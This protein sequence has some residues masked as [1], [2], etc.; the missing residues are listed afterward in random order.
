MSS[1][2]MIPSAAPVVGDDGAMNNL[3]SLSVLI[4]SN[5]EAAMMLA[6]MIETATASQLEKPAKAAAKPAAAKP[7][8]AVKTVPVSADGAPD[9]SEYRVDEIDHATCVA[10][11]IKGGDDKRWKPAIYREKQCGKAVEEGDLCKAC[12]AKE[13][14]YAAGDESDPK[15]RGFHGRVTEEPFGWTHMLGTA[16]A[17]A[18]KTGLVFL[19]D[20]A[21]VVS[22]EDNVSVNEMIGDKKK[23]AEEA[24][25]AAKAAKKAAADEA[26]AAKKAAADEAKAAKKAA[27]DEAK[28]IKAAEKAEKKP[29]ATKPKA[30]KEA[31]AETKKE[32]KP[33]A[34][35]AKAE[36]KAT[37][38]EPVSAGEVQY[39]D[40]ILYLIK[41]GGYAYEMEEMTQEVGDYAG[42]VRPD[43]TLDGDAEEEAAEESNSE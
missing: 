4:A 37:A 23:A 15:N 17:V 39:I 25:A 19:G 21:S 30:E 24:K 3:R 31:K 5:T 11:I 27:A 8:K 1:I 36:G 42:K 33:K 29:K 10:R 26:K 20:T 34:T 13:K 38:E 2:S 35:K 22:S 41:K 6:K 9:A 40:G 18:E 43:G 14:T 28:A 16:W 7:A 12:A 32:T